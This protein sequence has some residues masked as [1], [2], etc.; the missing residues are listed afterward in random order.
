MM[1]ISVYENVGLEVLHPLFSHL[2]AKKICKPCLENVTSG[3]INYHETN[4]LQ[5]FY[6]GIPL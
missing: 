4:E 5:P 3:G 1:L 2:G 6:L